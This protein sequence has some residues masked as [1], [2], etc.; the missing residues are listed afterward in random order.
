MSARHDT[1]EACAIC[2]KPIPPGGH[3]LC[4]PCVIANGWSPARFGYTPS[5][6]GRHTPQPTQRTKP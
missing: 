2:T 3:E 1:T 6:R 4:R 5:G